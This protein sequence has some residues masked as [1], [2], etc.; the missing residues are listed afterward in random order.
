M[1]SSN[2]EQKGKQGKDSLKFE[3]K[4]RRP[5][6]SSRKRKQISKSSGNSQLVQQ[7]QKPQQ[8]Q[9]SQQVQ[10]PEPVKISTK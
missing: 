1:S 4:P 6:E 5:F 7:V 3:K 8:V 9:K 2:Q 10:K